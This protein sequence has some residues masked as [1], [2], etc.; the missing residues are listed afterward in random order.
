MN[1]QF[2]TRKGSAIKAIARHLLE[3]KVD[4][5]L[6]KVSNL[7]KL[8]GFSVGY[9]TE[10][11]H[12]LEAQRA[13]VLSKQGRNGTLISDIDYTMLMKIADIGTV[14]CAMPLPYTKHYEGLAGG[15]KKQVTKFPFYF[16]HMRGASVR[17]ECLENQTYQMAIMSKLSAIPLEQKGE[18]KIALSLG[19]ESYTR[20]HVLISRED[21]KTPIQRIGVDPTSPDQILLTDA[22]FKGKSIEIIDLPYSECLNAIKTGFIDASIWC[23]S[24]INE[25]INLGFAHVELNIPECTYACEAVICIHKET[26]YLKRMLEL[27]VDVD[28]LRDYQFRVISGEIIP[29]Y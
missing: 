4:Q 28:Q 14:V 17:S 7:A 19:Q 10:A 27:Q 13:V 26:D 15:L 1:N 2:I 22:Y 11:I 20:K 16:A 9:A 25:L 3:K 29:S 12:E 23:P 8:Y 21:A 18:I 6:D 5:R 24:N